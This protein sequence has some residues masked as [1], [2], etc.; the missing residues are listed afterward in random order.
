MLTQRNITQSLIGQNVAA[1]TATRVENLEDGRIGITNLFGKILTTD[2]DTFDTIVIH[3]GGSNRRSDVIK[4]S[5]VKSI[6]TKAYA[7]PTNQIT[8]VG[9]NGTAGDLQAINNNNYI[10][11]INFV[12]GNRSQEFP[13]Q[14]IIQ[15]RFVTGATS[16]K[17]EVADGLTKNI[18]ASARTRFEND[19]KAEVVLSNVG[20]SAWSISDTIVGTRGSTTV[21]I[22]DVGNNASVGV[23][24]AGAYLRIGTGVT[25][26]CYK[27]VASTVTANGGILTLDQPLLQNVN[28]LGSEAEI[29]NANNAA[30]SSVGIKLSGLDRTFDLNAKIEYS[31]PSFETQLTNFGSATITA[32]QAAFLGSGTY[33]QVAT[34][35]LFTDISM[36]NRYRKDH[37]Y[38]PNLY[39]VPG[40]QYACVT[41]ETDDISP[42]NVGPVSVS[43]K[44]IRVW[45]NNAASTNATNF[46]TVLGDFM[47]T[48]YS[49]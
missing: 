7:A 23:I 26:P 20:S 49:F 9:Y 6:R 39:A 48:T 46:L 36:G 16:T 42:A 8:Y 35:D 17:L 37:L 45:F 29:I 33:E 11:R 4:R 14:R 18:N 47:G 15:G 22:T 27:I 21:V 1:T 34:E 32:A 40:G 31:K 41:I 44:I 19:I 24:A 10:L 38:S 28:L 13:M 5:N 12:T 2:A 43:P 3:Q 25:D 30:A